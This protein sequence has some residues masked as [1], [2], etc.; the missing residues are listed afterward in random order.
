MN[1]EQKYT[2]LIV[3]QFRHEL[4]NRREFLRDSQDTL[5]ENTEEAIIQNIDGEL[6]RINNILK[7]IQKNKI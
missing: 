7:L 2:S 3:D 1:K 4:L 6:D 5:P